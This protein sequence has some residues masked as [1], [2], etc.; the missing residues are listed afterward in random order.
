MD[1]Y[2]M[3]WLTEE[4]RIAEDRLAAKNCAKIQAVGGVIPLTFVK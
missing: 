3:Q 2:A 4:T 1:R